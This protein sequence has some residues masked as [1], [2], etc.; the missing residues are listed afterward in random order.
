[1]FHVVTATVEIG[2]SCGMLKSKIHLLM[3][4]DFVDQNIMSVIIALNAD[5]IIS[6]GKPYS[7]Y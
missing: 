5:Y 7:T 2:I 1:M 6:L 3:P 4:K